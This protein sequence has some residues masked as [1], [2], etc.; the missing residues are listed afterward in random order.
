VDPSTLAAVT[1]V[2]KQGFLGVT[3]VLLGTSTVKLLGL[4]L[5]EK[6]ARIAD[7]TKFNE[8]LRSEREGRLADRGAYSSS[9]LEVNAKVISAT[10]TL[11]ETADKILAAKRNG[12]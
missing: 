7:R 8:E 9:L 1:E 2:M 10:N 12:T 4:L 11:A 3:A 5:A 6:D